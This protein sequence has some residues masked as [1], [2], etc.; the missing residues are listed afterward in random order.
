[1]MIDPTSYIDNHKDDTLEQL[2]AERDSLYQEIKELFH[3]T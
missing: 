3:F 2:M 1:M